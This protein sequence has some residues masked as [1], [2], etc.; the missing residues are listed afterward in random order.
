MF[1]WKPGGSRA[2]EVVHFIWRISDNITDRDDSRAFALQA[3]ITTYHSRVMKKTL[4][5]ATVVRPSFIISK[6]VACVM[7]THLTWDHLPIGGE[8][9]QPMNGAPN[10]LAY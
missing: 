9:E 7:Y 2:G 3:D 10:V 4:F 6:A 8:M 1:S 5:L